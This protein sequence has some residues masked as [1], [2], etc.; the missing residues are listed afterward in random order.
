MQDGAPKIAFSWFISGL[1]MV[2]GRYNELVH[3]DYF[4]VYKPTNIT[5]GPHLVV[6][7]QF[8]HH[9][10]VI[11]P[12]SLYK[13]MRS[14]PLKAAFQAAQIRSLLGRGWATGTTPCIVRSHNQWPCGIDVVD[15]II[16]ISYGI[17][18]WNIV[19]YW[20]N[21]WD[22]QWVKVPIHWSFQEPIEDGGTDSRYVW[23]I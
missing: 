3:G 4:M 19:V 21:I 13:S 18:Y 15:P 10:W 6:E 9:F 2:Y 20:D 7:S 23:P 11:I 5:M 12:I 8:S 16:G 1:T 14:T 22:I 17:K